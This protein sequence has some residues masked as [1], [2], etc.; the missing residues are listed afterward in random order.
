MRPVTLSTMLND[1][2]QP[3]VTSPPH[4]RNAAPPRTRLCGAPT[5]HWHVIG[6]GGRHTHHRMMDI[7]NKI[8]RYECARDTRP[9]E[10]ALYARLREHCHE[11][12]PYTPTMQTHDRMLEWDWPLR[13]DFT[14]DGAGL[15]VNDVTLTRVLERH[16]QPI[17]WPDLQRCTVAELLMD[18]LP[19]LHWA[20]ISLD[21][22]ERGQWLST[23]RV[24]RAAEEL[25][26][27]LQGLPL[28]RRY[29]LRP[30][31]WAVM[32]EAL[33]SG[34]PGPRVPAG[35]EPSNFSKS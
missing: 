10:R 11:L 7:L 28:R 23:E 29:A 21:V 19:A 9:D 4:T 34:R 16:F 14:Y 35:A 24:Q 33:M 3:G 20:H 32:D 18:V 12:D 6:P 22:Y 31:R 30:D 17:T 5:Y 26:S 2:A 27:R 15:D 1:P 8:E 13:V 25:A